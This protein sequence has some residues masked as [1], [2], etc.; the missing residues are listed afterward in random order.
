MYIHFRADHLELDN[1]L[2][3]SSLEKLLNFS[4]VNN[5]DLVLSL[6][7]NNIN[8]VITINTNTKLIQ[9]FLYQINLNRIE[10]HS[11]IVSEKLKQTGMALLRKTLRWC[12]ICQLTLSVMTRTLWS[13]FNT[14]LHLCQMNNYDQ[15]TFLSIKY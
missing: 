11:K 14:V 10:C 9:F 1:Q 12:S 2:L 13:T 3:C 8:T 5:A 6:V 4:W 7:I 15:I